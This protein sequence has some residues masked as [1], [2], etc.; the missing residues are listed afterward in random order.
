MSSAICGTIELRDDGYQWRSYFAA[1]FGEK[2]CLF[3]TEHSTAPTKILTI[4]YAHEEKFDSVAMDE[5]IVA[6]PQLG[7]K[8]TAQ[9]NEHRVCVYHEENGG[10]CMTMKQLKNEEAA[11]EAEQNVWWLETLQEMLVEQYSTAEVRESKHSIACTR[12]LCN[13]PSP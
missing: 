13:P 11:E 2:M 12:T 8:I 5:F 9:K 7:N 3:K 10:G 1:Q 6:N 4:T